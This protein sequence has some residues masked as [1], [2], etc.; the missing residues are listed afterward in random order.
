MQDV[1]FLYSM[2]VAVLYT[3]PAEKWNLR[4]DIAESGL[5]DKYAP[6]KNIDNHRNISHHDI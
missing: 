3:L 6:D 5:N 1:Q 4:Q 2:K